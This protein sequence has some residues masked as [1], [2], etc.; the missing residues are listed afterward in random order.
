MGRKE[1]RSDQGGFEPRC[2]NAFRRNAAARSRMAELRVRLDGAPV[3]GGLERRVVVDRIVGV[4]VLVL[5]QVPGG[6]EG[7]DLGDAEG[8]G[9]V[10]Q[11]LPPDRSAGARNLHAG[12]VAQLQRLVVGGEALGV[13]VGA[14]VH[15][16]D[17]GLGPAHSRLD[18]DL[19]QSRDGAARTDPARV[20]EGRL[21]LPGDRLDAL[22]P[23]F[24][25]RRI[26]QGEP[27]PRAKG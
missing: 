22:L 14:L 19:A 17:R 9:L 18:T 20:M 4:E 5:G 11:T 12:R 7:A 26:E 6:V 23:A 10:L 1:A 3:A 15:H 27:D 21:L 2:P 24:L 16:L 25:A 13:G 8:Q